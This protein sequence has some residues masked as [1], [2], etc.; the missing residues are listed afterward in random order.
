M[1]R[2]KDGEEKC[3]AQLPNKPEGTTCTNPAGFRTNHL[4]VGAC[5]RHGGATKNHEKHAQIELARRECNRLGIE[6]E[7]DPADALVR[8]VWRA[9][10]NLMFY[11]AEVG[12][13]DDVITSETGPGGAFKLAAHPLVTLYHEAEKWVATVAASALRAGV[14]ERRIRMAERDSAQIIQAQIY[15]LTAMGLENR[16]DDFRTAFISALD[17]VER[18][19][20]T[21]GVI[22]TSVV[23]VSTT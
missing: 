2:A 9:Q 11:E 21:N 15:A 3:G 12:R 22:E 6:V 14:E 13:L 20:H 16:L 23:G 1:P 18:T 10:G 7:I 4:G 17:S 5:Y 8:A 19:A